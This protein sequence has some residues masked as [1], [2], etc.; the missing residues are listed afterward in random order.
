M[1]AISLLSLLVQIVVVLHWCFQ[2]SYCFEY[3][4]V[5]GIFILHGF[6]F[7]IS[8]FVFLLNV[9]EKNS[10]IIITCLLSFIAFP[11]S[12]SSRMCFFS[13]RLWMYF[14]VWN[15]LL[16]SSL[17]FPVS[18]SI[19]VMSC[20]IVSAFHVF[21]PRFHLVSSRILVFLL[22]LWHYLAL[23]LIFLFLSYC[24]NFS[25]FHLYCS[26]FSSCYFFRCFWT[27]FY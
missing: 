12:P 22:H 26:N 8:I 27:C 24:Y 13:V 15:I 7:S 19:S 23:S 5:K 10:V 21:L 4:K 16:E 20:V 3:S 25:I 18:S 11:S 17:Y 6:I 14:T 9:F 2:Y 1:S